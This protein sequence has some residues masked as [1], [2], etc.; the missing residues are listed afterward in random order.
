M[1][2]QA[3]HWQSSSPTINVWDLMCDLSFSNFSS[4]NVAALAF[5][6]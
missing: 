3:G 1:D 6:A 5:G 2:A 4:M